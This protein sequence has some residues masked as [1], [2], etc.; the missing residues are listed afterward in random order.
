M[1]TAQ[2]K[3]LWL[4]MVMLLGQSSSSVSLTSPALLDLN[5]QP[6][7]ACFMT[8]SLPEMDN[9]TGLLGFF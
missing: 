9:S 2:G 1:V 5:T 3:E 6:I 7:T 4:L 8:L